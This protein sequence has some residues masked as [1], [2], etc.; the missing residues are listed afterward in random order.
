MHTTWANLGKFL[1]CKPY[2]EWLKWILKLYVQLSVLRK[3]WLRAF[4]N[5][6]QYS[7]LTPDQGG[8]KLHLGGAAPLPP[9]YLPMTYR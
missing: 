5:N 3:L 2:M 9:F 8:Q 4:P 6:M 1:G 7:Q